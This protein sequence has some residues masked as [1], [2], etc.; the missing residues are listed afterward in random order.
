M[1]KILFVALVAACGGGSGSGSGVDSNKKLA[2][3]TASES[4]AECN[5]AY[6][7]YPQVTVTCPGGT[8]ITKGEDPTQR[9]AD[10]NGTTDVPAGC[11]V[12]VGQ[13]EACLSDIYHESDAALC[14]TN[15]L[16]P[17]SCAPLF[18]AACQDSGRTEP[19]TGQELLDLAMRFSR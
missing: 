7:T 6:D 3:L 15:T 1:K 19:M 14:S 13:V 11:T 10:C 2:D 18:S 17:A 12:T 5:Y 16:P 4:D 8:S 9:A